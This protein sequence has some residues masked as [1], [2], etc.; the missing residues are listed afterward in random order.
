MNKKLG[1]YFAQLCV[2][3][4][5]GKKTTGLHTLVHLSKNIRS[6]HVK[7]IDCHA[8]GYNRGGKDLLNRAHVNS[9]YRKADVK[10]QA[11]S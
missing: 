2:T 8:K 4:F 6:H 1:V 10:D 11:T 7:S 5:L 9:F 3:I